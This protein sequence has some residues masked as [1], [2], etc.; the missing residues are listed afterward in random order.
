MV[1]PKWLILGLVSWWPTTIKWWQFSQS[2][3]HSTIS[4]R[5]TE[6]HEVL[7][8]SANVQ[9]H[10]TS[11]FTN[12]GNASWY[13]ICRVPMVEWRLDCENCSHLTVV[14]LH[15]T[16]PWWPLEFFN[17]SFP[18]CN[19]HRT[20]GCAQWGALGRQNL[21]K[22]REIREQNFTYTFLKRFLNVIFFSF[23]KIR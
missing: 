1:D 23:S 5:Q 3:R 17:A 21:Y 19:A 14:G 12:D 22:Q 16:G 8:S 13:S 2:N 4:T 18:A 9:S 6:Y 20:Q 7:P 11:L 10:L 15:D